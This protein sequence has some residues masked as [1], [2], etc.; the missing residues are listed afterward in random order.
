[1][2]LN[3]IDSS[4]DCFQITFFMKKNLRSGIFFLVKHIFQEFGVALGYLLIC[5]MML[6][7]DFLDSYQPSH[8][9]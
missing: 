8:E 7:T 6:Y 9:L 2:V 5:S 1:M 4:S 3:F